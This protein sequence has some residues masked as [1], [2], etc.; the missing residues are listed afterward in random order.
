M[1]FGRG[2]AA[3]MQS[4][5]CQSGMEYFK[6]CFHLKL[7]FESQP[8]RFFDRSRDVEVG[9]NHFTRICRG[10]FPV[11]ANLV[12]W[13]QGSANPNGSTYVLFLGTQYEKMSLIT[14]SAMLKLG[15]GQRFDGPTY[16]SSSWCSSRSSPLCKNGCAY[17]STLLCGQNPMAS[18]NPIVY[19]FVRGAC[20]ASFTPIQYWKICMWEP[21]YA[22]VV[23]WSHID[24]Q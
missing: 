19:A 20:N 13:R 11:T 24:C 17:P 21:M 16:W 14:L 9:V 5:G 10:L 12:R 3:N 8:F 23:S 4:I 22:P 18:G 6:S 2:Q 1:V 7:G 15:M